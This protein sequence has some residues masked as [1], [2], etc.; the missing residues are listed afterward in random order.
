V[1]ST[2]AKP[3]ARVHGHLA[4]ALEET[5]RVDPETMGHHFEAAGDIAQAARYANLVAVPL[6]SVRVLTPGFP[7]EL[8]ALSG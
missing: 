1:A 3:L 4:L 6:K 7:D 2:G 5:T 8:P